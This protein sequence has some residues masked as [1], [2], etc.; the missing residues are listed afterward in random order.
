MELPGKVAVVTGAGNGIGQQ[1]ALTL[2]SKGASVAAVDI[3]TEA[4][5]ETEK[6][7]GTTVGKLSLHQTDI[8]D[9]TAVSQL[10]A[11]VIREHGAVDIVINNAGIV[12]SFET[13]NTLDYATI[14]RV[15]NINF[16]GVINMTKEFLPLL[17]ERPVAHVVNVSSMGGLFAFP[18]Q[19]IYGASKA[20]IKLLS[21][22]LY[23]EL[24]GT[25]VGVSVIFPGA[26]STN[27]TL[28][29]GAHTAKLDK[30]KNI[31]QKGTSAKTAAKG[32][33]RAIEKNKFRVHIGI[34]SKMLSFLYRC[35]PQST[36]LLLNKLIQ[37]AMK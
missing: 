11:E 37:M 2:L 30:F 18:T 15:M 29:S 10:T 22:G 7:A 1:I 26:I 24:R 5:G 25:N 17:L 31:H 28:N 16:Y 21:E 32:I 36:V 4:L 8:S 14:E 13:V 23:A 33:V 20:A 19:T 12:H 34:D 6:Q 27:I 3:N 9:R 35:F